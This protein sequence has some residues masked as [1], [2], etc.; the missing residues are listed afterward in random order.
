MSD[1][2]S[3]LQRMASTGT[4]GSIPDWSEFYNLVR[5]TE[6]RIEQQAAEIDTLMSEDVQLTSENKSM[7]LAIARHLEHAAKQSEE[8]ATLKAEKEQQAVEIR[9]L[10]AYID[11]K[12]RISREEIAA[13]R[14]Q[15]ARMPVLLGYVTKVHRDT[16]TAGIDLGWINS[17]RTDYY[18]RAV[19]IDP[20]EEKGNG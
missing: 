10:N 13:L 5:G 9:G 15:V 18:N 14:E 11:E 1:L 8:I 4:V 6:K 20:P 2:D 17:E 19:Y 16:L 3:H 12:T 7:K